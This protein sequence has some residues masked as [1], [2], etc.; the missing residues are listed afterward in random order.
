MKEQQQQKKRTAAAAS[1]MATN[2]KYDK[3]SLV[4]KINGTNNNFHPISS[5]HR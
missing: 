3:D 4:S 1:Q 5:V 2:I